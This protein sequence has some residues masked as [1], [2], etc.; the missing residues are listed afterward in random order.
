MSANLGEKLV[1][2]DEEA[3]PA[4]AKPDDAPPTIAAETDEL[5]NDERWNV[6]WIIIRIYYLYDSTKAF[7]IALGGML[8]SVLSFLLLGGGKCSI[9][10]WIPSVLIFLTRCIDVCF[11]WGVMCRNLVG[12]RAQD[13][14]GDGQISADEKAAAKEKRV[15]FGKIVRTNLK[16]CVTQLVLALVQAGMAIA[17]LVECYAVASIITIGVAGLFFLDALQECVVWF[18][19]LKIHKHQ[20]DIHIPARPRRRWRPRARH[21]RDASLAGLVRLPHPAVHPPLHHDVLGARIR[22]TTA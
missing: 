18:T 13:L 16:I 10:M 20:D 2:G 1:T 4:V 9:P 5:S 12:A 15:K 22:Y 3:P 19:C 17:A 8:T 6:L 14:D 7:A 21:R 11:G